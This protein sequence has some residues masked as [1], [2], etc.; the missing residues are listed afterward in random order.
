MS[1]PFGSRANAI[2]SC[3]ISPESCVSIG[4][5]VSRPINGA[6]VWIAPNWPIPAGTAESRMTATRCTL[7]AISLRNCSHL[8]PMLYSNDAKPVALLPGRVKL[9]TTPAPTGSAELVNT[10]GTVR[11]AFCTAR[12][13]GAPAARKTSG[14]SA[15]SSIAYLELSSILPAAQRMSIRTLRPT[16]QPASCSPCRKAARRACPSASSS[17]TFMSTPMRRTRS[18]CCARAAIG[19][20]TAAPSRVLNSRRLTSGMVSPPEPAVPAYRPLRLAWKHRQVLGLE[21]NCS[22]ASRGAASRP[23]GAPDAP[24]MPGLIPAVGHTEQTFFRSRCAKHR[25]AWRGSHRAGLHCRFGLYLPSKSS[26]PLQWGFLVR[27]HE[28][29]KKICKKMKLHFKLVARPRLDTQSRVGA[30]TNTSLLRP[31][32]K[33]QE[34]RTVKTTSS[35]LTGSRNSLL[36]RLHLVSP[37]L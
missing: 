36:R 17:S 3:S 23:N 27:C 11:V 16:S 29:L 10:I 14:A 9:A 12:T 35:C 31:F 32:C 20:A 8:P 37:K 22:E 15:S 1:P 34:C 30:R 5:V 13:V 26:A 2:T 18:P 19:Q 25:L 24:H 21:L 28:D 6:A 33:R 4:R 7:G